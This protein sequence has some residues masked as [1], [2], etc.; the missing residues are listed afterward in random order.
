MGSGA[1]DTALAAAAFGAS[2]QALQSS[3]TLFGGARTLR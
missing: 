2:A 1:S 3:A